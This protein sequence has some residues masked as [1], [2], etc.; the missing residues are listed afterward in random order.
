MNQ[1]NL[2]KLRAVFGAF[3]KG[4]RESNRLG[5]HEVADKLEVA[6]ETVE[7]WESAKRP[8]DFV[9][10][11]AYCL[12]IGFPLNKCIEYLEAVSKQMLD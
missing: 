8:I 2:S 6:K 1:D 12:A 10:L 9:E 7:Q 11:R 5:L 4:A 3:L